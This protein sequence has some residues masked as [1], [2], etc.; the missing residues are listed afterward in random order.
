MNPEIRKK[1]AIWL[2]LVFILGTATGGVFGYS[3]ARRS[4]ASTRTAAPSDAER[5][6]KKIAE[7]TQAIGLTAEQA[8]KADG[9]IKNAQSEIRAI[10][11]KS[12][13]EVDVLRMKNREQVRSLLTP[14][15][16]PK[17]EQFVQR[18]DEERK[19]QKEAQGG[20]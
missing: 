1:A 8:Q 14:E 19:K 5:R 6:A 10:H 20:R 16:L 2:A 15:Q 7:M 9:I 18:M 13:A 3:L 17:F 11:D 12:D 4:Y